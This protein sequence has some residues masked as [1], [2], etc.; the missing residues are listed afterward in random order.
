MAAESVASK[1]NTEA[2]RRERNRSKSNFMGSMTSSSD[3]PWG[4]D[5]DCIN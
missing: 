4:W 1:T 5:V 3:Q 2:R